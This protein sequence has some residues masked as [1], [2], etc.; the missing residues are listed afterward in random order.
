MRFL[1][2]RAI[3]ADRKRRDGVRTEAMGAVASVR[4]TAAVEVVAGMIF[5]ENLIREISRAEGL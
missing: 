2:Q 5:G 4:R 3:A 1:G